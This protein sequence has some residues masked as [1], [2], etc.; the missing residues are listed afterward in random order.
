MKN[1]SFRFLWI[2]QS[3]ANFGDVFYIVGLISTLYSV[4]ESVFYLA[5]LPFINTFGRFLSGFI[6]PVLFNKYKLKTLLVGSQIGKTIVLLGLA[7]WVSLQSI[8]SIWVLIVFI[9]VI[10]FLDGWAM[11]ATGAML[12]RVVDKQEIVKANSFVSVIDQTIQLGGWA[13][14]GIIVALIGGKYVIWVTFCLFVVS[15]IMISRIVDSTPFHVKDE[16]ANLGGVLKGSWKIIWNSSLF[17]SLHVVFFIEAIANVVW[18]AAI[19]YVFVSEVLEKSESWWGYINTTF[20]IGL[21]IGGVFCSKYFSIV[22][23]HLKKIMIATSF[24]VSIITFMYGLNSVAWMALVF[25]VLFGIVEQVKSIAYDTYIQ[26]EATPEELPKL[27]G[28][29][30]ALISL[31]FGL[32]SLMMGAIA[33]IFG[34]RYV[35][36]LAGFLLASAAI[37]LTVNKNCFP[38]NYQDVSDD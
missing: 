36:L 20:F 29:Q 31:T 13:L 2:G 19:I 9:L 27:Y 8:P 10:A 3:L 26:L 15:S 6:S 7:S 18:I 35:F 32:S 16:N 23:R 24:G 28:A 30:S 25:S 33:E 22:E 14:G 34:V 37:Y 1:N 4:S 17:R 21:L 38:E 12:P 5:L 11:P